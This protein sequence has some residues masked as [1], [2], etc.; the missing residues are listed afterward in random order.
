MQVCF[1]EDGLCREVFDEP[2]HLQIDNLSFGANVFCQGW[3]IIIFFDW[4]HLGS[5]RSNQEV[6]LAKREA[7]V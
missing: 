5:L 7:S 3:Q 4:V 6:P 2:F 1:E